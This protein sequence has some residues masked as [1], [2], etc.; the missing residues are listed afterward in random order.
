M[1][2][3]KMIIRSLFRRGE[4]NSIK[5]LSLSIGITMGLI[6]IAK[7]LFEYSYDNFYPDADRIYAVQSVG[8]RNGEAFQHERVSGGVAIGMKDEIAEIET[9]TRFTGLLEE[10]LVF[11]TADRK[12]HKGNLIL[13]DS[14]FFR[15]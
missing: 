14:C 11:Y 6:L 15:P 5:I 4:S 12:K 1:K 9:A 3:L 10:E 7:V 2:N 13:A 8:T